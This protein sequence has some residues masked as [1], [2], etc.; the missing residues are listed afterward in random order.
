MEPH[1]KCAVS[2]A[3]LGLVNRT[4][5]CWIYTSHGGDIV[6]SSRSF[7]CL[8]TAGLFRE[9]CV[10]L[11]CGYGGT[12]AWTKASILSSRSQSCTF[13]VRLGFDSRPWFREVLCLCRSK[14]RPPD[15]E[16]DRARPHRACGQ[17]PRPIR[18]YQQSVRSC[19]RECDAPHQ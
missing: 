11:R 9:K 10:R 19:S 4:E 1:P 7:L 16:R 6:C 3:G 15:Q 14:Q 13:R 5:G 17:V 8:S 18:K 2:R 12:Q